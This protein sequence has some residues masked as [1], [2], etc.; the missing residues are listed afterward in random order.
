MSRRLMVLAI[1]CEQFIHVH[2]S[3][4][5]ICIQTLSN[6][7]FSYFQVT[8]ALMNC[9]YKATARTNSIAGVNVDACCLYC[10][11]EAGKLKLGIKEPGPKRKQARICSLL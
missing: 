7:L 1:L 2:H 4:I 8:S 6:V 3:Q 11:S 9:S 10:L 5:L